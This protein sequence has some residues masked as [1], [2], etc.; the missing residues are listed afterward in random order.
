[1]KFA[2]CDDHFCLLK[3]KMLFFTHNITRLLKILYLVYIFQHF[4]GQ[5]LSVIYVKMCATHLYDV[6]AISDYSH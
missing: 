2:H 3:Y 4:L 1:M 6:E 5:Q